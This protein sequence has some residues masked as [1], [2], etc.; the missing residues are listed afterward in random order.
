M[1]EPILRKT[2]LKR[3]TPRRAAILRKR[4]FRGRK[5]TETPAS[6]WQAEVCP[7]PIGAPGLLRFPK[8]LEDF[9]SPRNAFFI[10]Q[11]LIKII[12]I[13]MYT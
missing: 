8:S 1:S 9:E 5:H 2:P 7:D 12:R 11:G 10:L 3:A 6:N 4:L 13:F